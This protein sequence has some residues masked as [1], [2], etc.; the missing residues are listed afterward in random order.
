[1]ELLLEKPLIFD[2]EDYSRSFNQTKICDDWL[3]YI[4]VVMERKLST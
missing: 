3:E 2:I 4:K 1:M